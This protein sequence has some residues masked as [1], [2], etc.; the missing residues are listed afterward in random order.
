MALNAEATSDSVDIL[1][2]AKDAGTPANKAVT[3]LRIEIVDLNDEPPSFTQTSPLIN[4][5]ENT[6][7]GK[8]T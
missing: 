2:E 5:P 6:D 8:R 3:T 4:V 7:I 1:V